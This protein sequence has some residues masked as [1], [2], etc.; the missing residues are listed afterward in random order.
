M[1]DSQISFLSDRSSL[2]F[3]ARQP[4]LFSCRTIDSFGISDGGGFLKSD[5]GNRAEG[6]GVGVTIPPLHAL[7]IIFTIPHFVNMPYK[8]P[9]P[10]MYLRGI[11][12]LIV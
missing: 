3:C 10:Q 5:F 4:V 7:R 2:V 11:S 9:L 8:N 12:I 1:V 6:V